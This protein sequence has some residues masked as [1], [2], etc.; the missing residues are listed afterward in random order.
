MADIL[1]LHVD[2][3]EEKV[4]SYSLREIDV[5]QINVLS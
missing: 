1:E 2:Y 3:V 5:I 4:K